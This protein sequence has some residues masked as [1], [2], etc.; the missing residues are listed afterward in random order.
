MLPGHGHPPGP[1]ACA[2]QRAKQLAKAFDNNVAEEG[3]IGEPPFKQTLRNYQ[4]QD[5]GWDESAPKMSM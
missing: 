5:V 2:H 4:L 1:A 3:C